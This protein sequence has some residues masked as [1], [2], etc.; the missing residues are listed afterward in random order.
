MGGRGG[1]GSLLETKH[2]G[3]AL[4]FW[5][6][7]SSVLVIHKTVSIQLSQTFFF[8]VLRVVVS[9]EFQVKMTS[10][11]LNFTFFFSKI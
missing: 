5:I 11:S 10:S 6:L 9:N 1:E 7:W 8:S 2:L 3:V 4:K